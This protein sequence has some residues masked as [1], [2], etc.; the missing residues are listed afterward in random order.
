MDGSAVESKV[1]VEATWGSAASCDARCVR[2]RVTPPGQA[3]TSLRE[4]QELLFRGECGSCGRRR[5]KTE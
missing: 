5:H 2:S 1:L 4:R 3:V